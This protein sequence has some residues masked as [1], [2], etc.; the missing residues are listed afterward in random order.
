[1]TDCNQKEFEFQG[2]K[3][4]KIVGSFNG[5]TITSDAGSLLLREVEGRTG[6]LAGFSGCFKDHRQEGSIEHTISELV[7]QRVY[8]LCLGYEDLNDHDVLRRDPLLALLSGKKDPTGQNRRRE[9]DRGKALAGKSTLNRLELTRSEIEGDKARKIVCRHEGVEDLFVD[10]FLK[11]EGKAPEEIVLDLDA[12]DDLIH[13]MQEG[14]FFHGY[15]G[16]YCYLPLYIFCGDHLLCAKLRTSD[17][18]GAD[19]ALEEIQRIVGRIR[20]KWP[21]VKILLRGDSGFCRDLLMNWAENQH[22]VDFLFGLAK[23]NRLK[24]EL[25]GAMAEAKAEYA[26]TGESSRR[27]VDFRYQTLDSWSRERRVVG[28][29]EYM[30]KGENPRFVVTSLSRERM[31]AQ[32]LYEEGYCARGEM[33]NRIKEQQLDL[34]ADRT[35]TET[36]RANQLRLWFSSV[37]YTLMHALRML[38]LRATEFAQAQCGTIRNKILK[39]GAQVKVSVRRVLVSFAS[40]YPYQGIFEQ[41]FLN[42]TALR[43]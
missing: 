42:L 1:M 30:E 27:F 17:R 12:T 19:G 3:S 25:E 37:A 14:R 35:S 29:A 32:S 36:M 40:G 10:I 39:I 33:E 43:L 28:K 21:A 38:G 5:G 11:L 34:F 7:S 8:G 2:L 20:Q 6:I 4:R 31:E 16:N 15:Y 23:N 41:V 22:Q 18:D 24:A 26:S 13:G 9:Q